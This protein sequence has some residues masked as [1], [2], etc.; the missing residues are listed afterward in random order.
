MA[1]RKKKANKALTIVKNPVHL[2]VRAEN[3]IGCLQCKL[4]CSFSHSGEF[5]P[6][7]GRLRVD[8]EPPSKFQLLPCTL[9][10]KCINICPTQALEFNSELHYI[11]F[12]K[13]KC[14]SCKKCVPACPFCIVGWNE[15]LKIPFIC[16]MCK[17]SPQCAKYCPTDALLIEPYNQ[18]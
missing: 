11:E 10:G 2:L 12:I 4:I 9:C 16:D 17:G 7:L 8:F 13:E 14:V 6:E 5:N 3:C 15:T 18:V 1:H